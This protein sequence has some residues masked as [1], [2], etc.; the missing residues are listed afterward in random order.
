MTWVPEAARQDL[1]H[2]P[3]GL[4]PTKRPFARKAREQSTLDRLY[5]AQTQG[6]QE[7]KLSGRCYDIARFSS[8]P[9]MTLE[10]SAFTPPDPGAY[11]IGIPDLAGQSRLLYRIG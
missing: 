4:P 11:G 7:V 3:C 9:S 8:E 10:E 6:E 2:E 1:R 5:G